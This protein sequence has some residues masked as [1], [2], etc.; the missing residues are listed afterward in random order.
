MVV[1][2]VDSLFSPSYTPQGFCLPPIIP[3]FFRA[4]L[5]FMAQLELCRG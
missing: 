4:G 2:K 5:C 3:I 1:A